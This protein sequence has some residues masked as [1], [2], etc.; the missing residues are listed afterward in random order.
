M[1]LDTLNDAKAAES[2]WTYSKITKNDVDN[3]L[4]NVMLS[5]VG[6]QGEFIVRIV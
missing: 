5:W 6:H 1:Q 4:K 3:L 2:S